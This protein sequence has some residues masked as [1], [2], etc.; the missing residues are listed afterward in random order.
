MNFASRGTVAILMALS[1]AAAHPQ[2]EYGVTTEPAQAWLISPA[3]AVKYGGEQGFNAEPALRARSLAPT[4]D[5]LRPDATAAAKVKSPFAIAVVFRGQ[6]DSAIDP[7]SFKVLYGAFKI[8]ITER[9]TRRVTVTRDGFALDNAQIPAGKH[10]LTLQVAD[11]RQRL[12]EREL[13]FEVVE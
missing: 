13:R 10:R 8:D 5:I 11:D 9:I 12:A 2:G 3:E 6:G 1:A 7:A 4:I